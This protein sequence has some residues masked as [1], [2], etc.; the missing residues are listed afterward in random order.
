M[1]TRSPTVERTLNGQPLSLGDANALLQCGAQ[2]AAQTVGL[3]AGTIRL[4][5]L[6]M[7][8]S[9]EPSRDDVQG[10]ADALVWLESV[11]DGEVAE[12]TD[13]VRDCDAARD[14]MV[15]PSKVDAVGGEAV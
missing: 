3:A 9:K 15:A 7:H 13:A 4:M 2:H 11:L 6:A 5:S 8:E 14:R 1:A 12:L 10:W